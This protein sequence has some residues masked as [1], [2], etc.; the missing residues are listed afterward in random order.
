[1]RQLGGSA[2]PSA[3]APSATP[4]TSLTT[5]P[6]SY[7]LV[8]TPTEVSLQDLEAVAAPRSIMEPCLE[9]AKGE[10]G[11]TS[12]RSSTGRAGT[13]TSPCRCQ[14]TPG[15]PRSARPRRK[16]GRSPGL[17]MGAQG[18]PA[19]DGGAAAARELT[20]AWPGVVV[21][22]TSQAPASPV[23]SSLSSCAP[24]RARSLMSH[25][26]GSSTRTMHSSSIGRA[27]SVWE[28]LGSLDPEVPPG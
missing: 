15:W 1:M 5:W 12:P 3:V 10:T 11:W 16:K 20:G 2:L 9:E 7:Y 24:G 19:V 26:Y 4:T 21:A 25:N 18:V 13:A 27:G 28:K 6:C 17:A 22:E 8:L 14:P 23:P